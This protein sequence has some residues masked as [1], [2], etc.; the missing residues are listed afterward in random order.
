MRKL[1]SL[2]T[3]IWMIEMFWDRRRKET[4][5][6]VESIA[7]TVCY[8]AYPCWEQR[9][10]VISVG[11]C[12]TWTLQWRFYHAR[13][14]RSVN[15]MNSW[16]FRRYCR[17]SFIDNRYSENHGLS[18]LQ[19]EIMYVAAH[20]TTDLPLPSSAQFILL[21]LYTTEIAQ[22]I[23]MTS[24]PRS[25]KITDNWSVQKSFPIVINFLVGIY[26]ELY[27]GYSRLS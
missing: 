26:V 12:K 20:H 19:K 1:C 17:R 25:T 24:R 27:Y 4:F 9:T 21:T 10:E 15:M 6:F 7:R 23:Y 2:N 22:I 16:K 5:I 18:I 11:N 14:L 8:C 3:C 13:R